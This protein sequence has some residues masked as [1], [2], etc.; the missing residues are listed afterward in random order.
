MTTD[1]ESYINPLSLL[2]LDSMYRKKK[3]KRAKS[4]V[5]SRY[6]F[7]KKIFFTLIVLLLFTLVYQSFSSELG[8]GN[9]II[10][11]LSSFENSFSGAAT[12]IGEVQSENITLK[13]DPFNSSDAKVDT[14][15]CGFG[16]Q[17]VNFSSEMKND[18]SL[19]S[20]NSK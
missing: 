17:M 10:Q 13:D 3:V 8:T 19:A 4:R 16:N 11:K 2:S 12:N 6:G 7:I 9:T 18:S 20:N 5:D 1:K 14:V 15:V